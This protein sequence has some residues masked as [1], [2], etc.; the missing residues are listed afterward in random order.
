VALPPTDSVFLA[1]RDINHTI[2][3]DGGMTCVIFPNWPV[4][5]GYDRQATDLLVRLPS[6]YPDVP[7]DMWWFCPGIKLADGRAAQATEAIERHL[8]R[9]WQRWSR[10]FQA[11]QWRSGIDGLESYLALIRQE[12]G[13]STGVLIA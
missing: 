2:A 6:G 10:H 12:L 8:G 7:P 13:R 4:P 11:G 5:L 1:D 3:L 9:D